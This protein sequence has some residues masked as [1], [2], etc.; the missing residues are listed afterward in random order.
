MLYNFYIFYIDTLYN[1]IYNKII[2]GTQP[3]FKYW[4]EK[5]ERLYKIYEMGSYLHY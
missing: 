5:H 1:M 4:R 2:K 3:N